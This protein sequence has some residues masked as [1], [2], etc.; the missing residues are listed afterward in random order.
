ME[1][2]IEK[3]I[4]RLE[5]KKSSALSLYVQYADTAGISKYHE[6]KHKAFDF[7]IGELQKILNDKR[8]VSEGDEKSFTEPCLRCEPMNHCKQFG[9]CLYED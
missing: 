1:K 8:S 5:K 3:F 6:G 9:K 7:C 4:K 2:E